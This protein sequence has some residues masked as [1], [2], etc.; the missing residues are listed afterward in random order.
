MRVGRRILVVTSVLVL[1]LAVACG[2]AG[3]ESWRSR[4]RADADSANR[5]IVRSLRLT[6]LSLWSEARY[7]RHPA[8]ADLFSPFADHPG[9]IEHFPA[10]SMV[11]PPPLRNDL[12]K[13]SS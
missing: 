11:P 10:G 13:K 5:A 2:L 6:S 9:S 12:G 8:E 4:L 1:E 3:Y 7:C